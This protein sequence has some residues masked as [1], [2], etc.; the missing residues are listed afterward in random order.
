MNIGEN[1]TSKDENPKPFELIKPLK[2]L[3]PLILHNPAYMHNVN[4]ILRFL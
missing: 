4:L 3:K 1:A 2:P